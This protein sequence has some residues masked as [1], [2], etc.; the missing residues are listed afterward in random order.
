MIVQILAGLS[1]VSAWWLIVAPLLALPPVYLLRRVRWGALIA[2]LVCLGLAFLAWTAPSSELTQLL[3]RPLYLDA[4]SA[5][6]IVLICLATACLFWLSYHVSQGWSFY[7]FGLLILSLF[8]AIL[9]NRHLGLIALLFEMVV[10]LSVFIIQGGRFGSIRATLRFFVM[11]TLA[12]PLMLLA[13][14]L[15]DQ[16]PVNLNN[17]RV[18][19]QIAWLAGAGFSL[20]LGVAPLHGWVSSVATEAK[21]GVAAFILIAFPAT[22]SIILLHLMGS[23]PWLTNVA[24]I[25]EVITVAGLFTA[26]VGGLFAGVQ[27]SFGSLMGYAALFD[28]G[29]ILVALGNGSDLGYAILLLSLFARTI[30]LV[31]IALSLTLIDDRAGGDYFQQVQGLAKILPIPTAGLVFG[32]LTLAGL[33]FT[34]GFVSRWMLIQSLNALNSNGLIII[35]LLG[36][37]GVAV[38][39]TRGLH[40]LA[41]EAP[42][43]RLTRP[44]LWGLN[45]LILGLILLSLWLGL[46]PQFIVDLTYELGQSIRYL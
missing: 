28:T 34:A 43:S 31:L 35:I 6:I 3:G 19:T 18:L 2:M 27:R 22:T 4:I 15:L 17:P 24:G 46:F 37:L 26:A 30:A 36:S 13:A 20:W 44:Q 21:P 23:S 32:G 1:E 29:T 7:P 8:S 45:L 9:L 40:A 5:Y 10:L 14:W 11:L 33:P 25:V 38:G 41:Q 12:V 39:Y 16:D 42:L